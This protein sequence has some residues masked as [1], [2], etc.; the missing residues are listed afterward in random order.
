MTRRLATRNTFRPLVPVRK[1][2]EA[3][4]KAIQS[5]TSTKRREPL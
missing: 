1:T 4:V 5:R 3:R 2:G